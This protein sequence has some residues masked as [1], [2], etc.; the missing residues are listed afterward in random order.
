MDDILVVHVHR[1]GVYNFVD[2]ISGILVFHISV[3]VHSF[4][5]FVSDFGN[6]LHVH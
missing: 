6:F 4:Q 2:Y 3:I 1:R 5:K